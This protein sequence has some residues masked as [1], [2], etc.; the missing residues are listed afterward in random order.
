LFIFAKNR[1]RGF[2]FPIGKTSENIMNI[3][4]GNSFTILIS[5]VDG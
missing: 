5:N 4:F 2:E 1:E 3:K